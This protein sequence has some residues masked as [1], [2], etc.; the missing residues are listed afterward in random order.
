VKIFSIFCFALLLV[1]CSDPHDTKLPTDIS[2]WSETVKPALEKLKPEEK[3]LFAQYAVRHTMGA[4]MGG[5]FGIKA[6]PIPEGMTIG[7]AIEEQRDYVAKANMKEAEEKALKEK[8]EA[9]RKA[10]QEEFTKLLSV[11]LVNKKDVMREYGRR[12]VNLE[13]AFENKSDKDIAGVKGVL[14]ITDIFGDKIVNLRWSNDTGIKAKQTMVERGSG[15]DINQFMDEHMKLWNTDYDK[16]KST[17][18]VSTILFKDG[19]KMDAP[20]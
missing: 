3:E 20:E 13:I 11:V 9:E 4:A 6:D 16:L 17:F 12:F 18:E 10:K 15:M 5:L 19:T 2:K 1:A 7:K 8:V 14:K